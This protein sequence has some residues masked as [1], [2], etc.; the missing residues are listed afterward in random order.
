MRNRKKIVAVVDDDRGMLDAVK[1]LLDAYGFSTVCFSS[2]QEFITVAP[3]TD[4]LLLDIQL[5]ASSGFELRN[6]LKE[7]RSQLPVIFMTALHTKSIYEEAIKAGC[8]A[9]LRKPFTAKELLDAL[10][11][12][13]PET[14]QTRARGNNPEAL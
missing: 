6:Q 1:K 3:Q 5:R 8:V 7:S 11:L 12:A 4:C 2:A 9:C 10:D 13:A 14:E